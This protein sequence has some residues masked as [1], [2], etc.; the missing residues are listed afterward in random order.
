MNGYRE[1]SFDPNA[2]GDYGRPMRPFNWVQWLGVGAFAVGLGIMLV[3]F[4][5]N[6][7][8]I[9][10]QLD[11]PTPGTAFVLI[12]IP[13]INSRREG[14]ALTPATKGRRLIIIAVALAVCIALAA[15]T[16]YFKGA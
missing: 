7:G 11:S 13:L 8:L 14:V 4:A 16:I 9:A 12:A 15:A 10:K 3:Y 1:S 6:F 5:G 2:G